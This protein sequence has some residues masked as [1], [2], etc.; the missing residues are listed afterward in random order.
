MNELV[1]PTLTVRDGEIFADSRD[2]ATFFGKAHKRVLQDI[3]SLSG[4]LLAIGAQPGQHGLRLSTY[5]GENSKV[6]PKYD[7]TKDGLTLLVMRYTGDEALRFQLA[8]IA[9]FN[10][11]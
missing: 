9:E 5:V 7:L 8:Y 1:V 6:L 4:T 10:R 2:V 3:R 11:M